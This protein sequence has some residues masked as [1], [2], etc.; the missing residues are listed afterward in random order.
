M[1]SLWYEQDCENF[2]SI[3]LG[4]CAES[5]GMRGVATVSTLARRLLR[6]CVYAKREI[7][8]QLKSPT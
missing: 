3:V 7:S 8:H 4:R 5:P 1:F 6:P 2:F